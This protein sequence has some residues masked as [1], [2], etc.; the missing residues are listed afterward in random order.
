V[1]GLGVASATIDGEAVWC[2]GAGLETFD[3]LHSRAVDGEVSLYAFDLLGLDGEDWRPLAIA[4]ER[5]FI[6]GV[7]L[8]PRGLRR[9][10]I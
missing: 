7:V 8:A 6:R 9:R 3:K 2:D 5:R 4:V 1:A 10:Q